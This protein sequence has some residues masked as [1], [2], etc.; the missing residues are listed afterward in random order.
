MA[1][2]MNANGE[3]VDMMTGEIV[4]A[5]EG[6]A[7]PVPDPR[8]SLGPVR[9]AGDAL[10][11][12]GSMVQNL[13]WGF[14]AGLFALPDAGVKLIGRGLGMKDDEV[15]TLT[16]LFNRGDTGP[17]GETDRYARAIGEGIG[18]GM[19][20]TGLL[21]W[22]AR[23]T[24]MVRPA[25][26]A[27][28]GLLKNIA[29]EA[30]TFAQKSPKLAAGMDIAFNAGYEAMRQAV[31]ENVSED[32]PNKALYKELL[33]MGAFVGLP[34]A[35]SVLPSTLV[36]KYG[37]NKIRSLAGGLPE[38]EADVLEGLPRYMRLPG[39]KVVPKVLM[40]NAERKL[41]KVFGPI[42][43]SPEAQQ[44]LEALGR[45]L[46]D[47][48]IA[49]AGFS[50]DVAEKTMF[51]ALL[52]E[53]KDL[54]EKLGPSEL[55][56]VRKRINENQQKLQKLMEDLSP[57]A[58]QDLTQ[59]FLQ[60]QQ[61]RDSFFKGLLG[62]K[63]SLTDAEKERLS[64]IYGPLDV[65]MIND[66]LRGII[67]AGMEMDQGMR[68]KILSRMGMKK[69]TAEDGTPMA[70]RAE[71]KSLF[72]ATDME[73]A[74]VSLVE[75]YRI[76]RPSM[77][78]A[79]PEPIQMLERFVQTQQLARG[80]L[81]NRMVDQLLDQ[82]I[83]TQMGEMGVKLDGDMLKA[84]RSAASAAIRGPSKTGRKGLS[85]GDLAS[86]KDSQGFISIPTG[87]PGKNV[88]F[89]PE[90]IA[91]DATRIAANETAIDI[92][93]PEGLDYLESAIR[94]RNDSLMRYNNALKK[95]RSRPTDAQRYLDTGEAVF[96]DVEQLVLGHVPRIKA[97]YANLKMVVD[98]YRSVYEQSLPLLMT[99]RTPRGGAD[100]FLLPNE[101]VMQTAFKT[102]DGV[103]QLSTMLAGRTSGDVRGKELLKLGAYDWL[104]A[105]KVFDNDGLVDPRKIKKVLSENQ[106]ILN[107]LPQDIRTTL[108]DEV[109]SSEQVIKRLGEIDQ[110]MVQAKDIELDGI[111]QKA[112][113]Q[114]ADP[115]QVLEKAVKDPAQM[116]TLVN[117][118][119]GDPE[120]LA[121]L[122]RS[123]FEVATGGTAQG[124][125]LQGFLDGNRKSLSILFDKQHLTDLEHLADLQR[126]V[127]AFADVTGQMPAFESLDETLKG[128]FGSGIQY[129]TTTMRE[130]AVGRI[131]PETGM[132]ALMIR[133][134]ANTENKIYSRIFTKA[135]E[136]PAFASKMANTTTPTQAKALTVE[137]QKIG[138]DVP[139]MLRMLTPVKQGLS[140]DLIDRTQE[141]SDMPAPSQG[142]ARSMLRDLPPAPKLGFDDLFKPA[143]PTPQQGGA[144][145]S[146]NLLYPSL[147]PRDPISDMLKQRAAGQVPA[148][149]GQ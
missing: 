98:D 58:K 38:V 18:A 44:A 27:S 20:F 112:V 48:R 94:F 124:G 65:D 72:P 142:A 10:D 53:K 24:P 15:Q 89:N 4:G 93:M 106:N 43:E 64:N 101:K 138:V 75:K 96:K 145:A 55:L 92:N 67:Y 3:Y 118:F 70:T 80:K 100:Q 88:R 63:Q 40:K 131:R 62:E 60:V 140:Q 137:L 68:Q 29:D 115:A 81:Q 136:D 69:A 121:S 132:I 51:G 61:E 119:K 125:A 37:A 8:S 45:A 113:K 14:N 83:T 117:A 135:L 57:T 97:D 1:T 6:A 56:S 95:G 148:T 31:E 21:S 127:N 105:K 11:R 144:G 71:G 109:V 147:F 111:V 91:E 126:R 46:G 12:V 33:P 54:L 2:L 9:P 84:V 103:R 86:A 5:A 143:A 66:E 22:A 16:K 39:L 73:A 85:F 116:R 110:R 82:T 102:A 139:R 129:M 90:T 35:A 141:P 30:V 50:F 23:A 47:P 74:L 122:R 59:S 107:A 28:Q 146:P 25:V 42:D 34:M 79:V 99:E 52:S 32:N 149:P 49:E 26:T 19:P 108:L 133:L 78:V 87:I 76:E 128:M 77:S 130:A 41:A 123:V 13:S 17:R 7:A 36:A 120:K 104:R 114:D 134:V